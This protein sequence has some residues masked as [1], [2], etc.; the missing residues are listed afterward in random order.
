M[1]ELYQAEWCPYS[2]VVRQRLTELGL[3]FVA[4]QVEPAPDQRDAMEAAVG[5]RIIP[6]LRLDDGTLLDDDAADIVEELGR[7]F[8][9]NEHTP[10]HHR[11]RE[12]AR[13]FER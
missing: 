12:E 7:R 8:E 3:D 9:G 4:H 5:S 13:M 10:E 2:H 6:V 1:I 11:R